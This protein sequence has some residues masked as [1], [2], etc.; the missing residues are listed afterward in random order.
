MFMV[1]EEVLTAAEVAA[2]RTETQTLDFGDGRAT[3]GK[4]AALVKANDQATPSPALDAICSKVGSALQANPVFASAARPR[5]L[6]P[7]ILSRYRQGQTYGSHV[8]DALMQGLRT[9][10]SFTL[11]LSDPDSYD[12]GAL[13]VED[14]LEAREFKLSAGDLLLYPSTALHRVSPVT[15]GERLGIVGWVQSWIRGAQEREILF[16]LDRSIATLFEAG[17]KTEVF[18]TLCKTRSNL[19]RLWAET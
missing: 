8:D 13:V 19:L 4:H 10:M 2:V 5:H 17:G 14:T 16:D 11:F 7:L 9:D 6:T 18:D 12:G 1:I 15:G 3:A